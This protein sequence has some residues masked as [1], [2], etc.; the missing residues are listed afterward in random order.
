M[1]QQKPDYTNKYTR[2]ELRK[3]HSGLISVFG[4]SDQAIE[5]LYQDFEDHLNRNFSLQ[6]R[7]SFTDSREDENDEDAIYL[8]SQGKICKYIFGTEFPLRAQGGCF[9]EFKGTNEKTVDNLYN[10]F[11]NFVSNIRTP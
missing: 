10:E 9:I 3:H 1:A 11:I 2:E 7:L 6:K 5:R 4:N 8:V